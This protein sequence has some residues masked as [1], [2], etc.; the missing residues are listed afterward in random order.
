MHI[1]GIPE[2][3]GTRFDKLLQINSGY[4][5]NLIMNTYEFDLQVIKC[6]FNLV[7]I[8]LITNIFI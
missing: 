7:S 6:V 8:A 3:H 5:F 4:N 1:S 2:L